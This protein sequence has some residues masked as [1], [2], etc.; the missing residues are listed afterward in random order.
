MDRLKGKVALITGATG[1][2]GSEEALLF[3]SEGARVIVAAR[4]REKG[5]T[6]VNSIQQTGGEAMYVPL[7]VTS[8]EQWTEAVQ[9][10]NERYGSLH[11]LVNNA[12]INNTGV[13]PHICMD[14]WNRVFQTDV[15]GCLM[16]IQ[17]CAELMR[18]S[19]GG[20]IVNI[21]STVG[22]EGHWFG[23]Y[24]AS[25]WA[26]RGLTRTAAYNLA[27]WNIRCNT[28]CPGL[29]DTP[30]SMNVMTPEV[31]AQFKAATAMNRGCSPKEI[32]FAVLF[33][34]SDEASYITGIDLPVDGGMTGCGA[35]GQIERAAGIL[36]KLL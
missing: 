22:L 36:D 3:A 15:N 6:L 18:D 10:V 19:G 29:V 26:M 32:A 16:G 27:R 17:A 1:G 33:L 8:Q 21:G 20:A 28:V 24:S 5:E 13:L 30:L 7:D 11:I 4:S 25:K 34:A 12:G 23:A 35:Y 2:Q 31:V 14:D 9:T